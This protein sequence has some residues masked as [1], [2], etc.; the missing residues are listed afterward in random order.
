[1]ANAT[2]QL[3][4]NGGDPQGDVL[5]FEPGSLIQGAAQI[6]PQGDIRCNHVFIRLQWHTEGRGDRD[7]G[8]VGEIDI[9]QGTLAANMPI[10]QS[11]NFNLP[12]EPWSF[13]G[14]YVNS[15]WEVVV[16]IDIPLAPDIRFGQPFILAPRPR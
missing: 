3:T 12:R 10:G 13:A 11:F 7:E 15:I 4:L 1:M 5:R 16:V 2:I 8:K 14:H 6:V 9:A